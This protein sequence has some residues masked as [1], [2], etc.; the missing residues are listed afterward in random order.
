MVLP[1]SAQKCESV[2]SYNGLTQTA[3]GHDD[4]HV[5]ATVLA[6]ILAPVLDADWLVGLYHIGNLELRVHLQRQEY[7]LYN[8]KRENTGLSSSSIIQTFSAPTLQWEPEME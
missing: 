5:A 1:R 7:T 2:K 4:V 8:I 6:S 3:V